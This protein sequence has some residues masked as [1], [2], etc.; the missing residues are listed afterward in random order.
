V[1]S[2]QPIQ[3]S[4]SDESKAGGLEEITS[5]TNLP[6]ESFVNVLQFLDRHEIVSALLVSKAW[7]SASRHA[8]VWEDGLDMSW[9]NLD[10][11]LNMTRLLKLLG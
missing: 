2:F 8:I 10:R 4:F 9:L 11:W 7:L 6:A 5:T 1:G 3:F